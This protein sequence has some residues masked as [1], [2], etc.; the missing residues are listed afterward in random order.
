MTN[1]TAQGLERL[2]WLPD[3]DAGENGV[4]IAGQNYADVEFIGG[5]IS[6]VTLTDVTING[7]ATA[8]TERVITAPGDVTVASNDYVITMN[9]TVSQITT[10]TLPASPTTSR[11][12]I[13]KDGKPDAA[14]FNITIDGNGKTIDGAATLVLSI[15]YASVEIIYNGTEWNV[16]SSTGDAGDVSGPG[17]STDN[18]VPKFVGTTGQVIQNTGVLI[19]DSN[20]MTANSYTASAATA[21]RIASFDGSKVISSLDTATYPSLTELSYVKGVTS[22]IQTQLNAK[23][24]GDV[25]KVGMPVDN[26]VGVWTGDGTIEGTTGLTYDGSNLLVT[27]DIGA[28]GTRITK[29]WFT[30]LEVTNA[31]AGSITGNAATVTTNADLTGDVTSVGNATTLATVNG[32]VGSFGSATQSLSVTANAKGLITAISAQTV[33][34][35]VGSI[36]GLGTGVATALAINVGSAGAPVVLNGALGTPS[37]GVATNLTGTATGLTAGVTNALASASTTINVSSATAPTNGQVLTATSGTTAT[38]QSPASSGI[39]ALTGDVTASGSGSV[40]ATIANNAVTLAKLATQAGNTVLAEATGSTAVPTAVAV[41]TGANNLVQLN[42][43]SQLPAVSGALLTNLPSSLPTA[44]TTATTS[45]T[46][47][48]LTVDFTT[49]QKYQITFNGV[50]ANSGDNCTIDMSSNGGGAYGTTSYG[51]TRVTTTTLTNQTTGFARDDNGSQPF[52]GVMTV[53]QDSTS[54][55]VRFQSNTGSTATP[56]NQWGGGTNNLSA[57]CDRIRFQWQTGASFDAGSVSIQPMA[58]R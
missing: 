17:S 46:S 41:G 57:A 45:G 5:N 40:A 37:S 26:Q 27:G 44:T 34:P 23:G 7:T 50:G 20:N 11:S 25:S 21:S 29:G 14:L 10:V 15:D 42:G 4:L 53:W 2:S 28:T 22:A 36:T 30:D 47:I 43:S 56:L 31:I 16:I 39:T 9:K 8:R 38:W 49:Y 54:G 19:D 32:N 18:A 35:A 6:N 3:R 13:I 48:V 55:I 1:E 33:T 12:L 24:T 51:Y 52:T 58:L